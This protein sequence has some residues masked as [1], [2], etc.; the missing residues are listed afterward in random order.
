MERME[1]GGYAPATRVFFETA[2]AALE[3]MDPQD[4]CNRTGAVYDAATAQYVVTYLGSEAR[5]GARDC[6]M[7]WDRPIHSTF[8][9]TL[10]HYL[11]QADGS[12]PKGEWI[13]LHDAAP[14]GST[15]IESMLKSSI[16]PLIDAFAGDMDG[17]FAA[18]AK[19]GGEKV[20]KDTVRLSILPHIPTQITVWPA[21]D[22]FPAD[23]RVIFDRTLRGQLF[24]EDLPYIA[25]VAVQALV[26]ASGRPYR[27]LSNM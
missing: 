21:D 18:A 25:D 14:V 1:I 8:H 24:G 16:P 23:A 5:A 10:L 3:K 9:I 7:E 20:A 11:M 19:I 22:E 26:Y 27:F 12:L 4:V 17:F 6:A 13:S 2:R 15:R